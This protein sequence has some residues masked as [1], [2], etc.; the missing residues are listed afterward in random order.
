[1]QQ[2]P[3]QAT[4]HVFPVGLPS[5]RNSSPSAHWTYPFLHSSVGAS[6]IEIDSSDDNDEDAN[7][8]VS[9]KTSSPPANNDTDRIS[10]SFGGEPSGG[11]GRRFTLGNSS[12][13]RRRLSRLMESR[14][15]ALAQQMAAAPMRILGGWSLS[16]ADSSSSSLAG[17]GG[18]IEKMH[19]PMFV[20]VLLK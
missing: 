5:T 14:A 7:Q 20:K 12:R 8:K 13:S 1:M 9:P 15:P 2:S 3:P 4:S 16:A 11:E 18:E 19:F 6:S 17:E 10:M